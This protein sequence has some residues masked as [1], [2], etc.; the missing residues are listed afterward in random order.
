[1]HVTS[2]FPLGVLLLALAACTPEVGDDLRDWAARVRAEAPEPA[3]DALPAAA[4][5][6]FAYD[7]SGRRDPFDA[8]KLATELSDPD[9]ALRPD[10]GRP[11][12][13]LEAFQLD[14]LQ[15]VGSLRRAGKSVAVVQAERQLHQ[16]SVGDHL[17]QDYGQV[18]AISED[19]IAIAERVQDSQGKWQVRES[20]LTLRRGGGK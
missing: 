11:R 20:Q 18:T 10:A 17:G 3:I 4:P 15:M 12:D 16:V 5:P 19:R 6:A 2:H 1:M 14:S 8:S 7:S 9:L 13:V